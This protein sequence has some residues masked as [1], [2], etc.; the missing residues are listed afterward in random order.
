[1]AASAPRRWRTAGWL[2]GLK[3]TI[4]LAEEQIAIDVRVKNASV[5]QISVELSAC[6]CERERSVGRKPRISFLFHRWAASLEFND[7]FRA[8][9]NTRRRACTMEMNVR[10]YCSMGCRLN[11][12]HRLCLISSSI[13]LILGTNLNN[14]WSLVQ[15]TVFLFI[16][17][18]LACNKSARHLN[19][20][21]RNI[22]SRLLATS[23]IS[24]FPSLNLNLKIFKNSFRF[25]V[26]VHKIKV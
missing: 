13:K 16:F 14:S 8:A 20:C 7:S 26:T 25:S 19:F 22:V 6:V 4:L 24:L 1:M 12:A 9:R 18:L 10:G 2:D 5:R 23:V 17:M 15:I 11:E 3:C 21:M